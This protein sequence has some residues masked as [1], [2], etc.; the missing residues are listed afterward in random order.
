MY[1]VTTNAPSVA[2]VR[3][4]PAPHRLWIPVRSIVID[5][6]WTV[7]NLILRVR[8]YGGLLV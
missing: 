5:H 3:A 1:T 7:D 8:A 4:K 2:E 6:Y